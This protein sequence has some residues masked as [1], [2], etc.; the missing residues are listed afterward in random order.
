M[1]SPPPYGVPRAWTSVVVMPWSRRY[2][3]DQPP[4]LALPAISGDSQT[5]S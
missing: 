3:Y 2:M 4:L 1:N 5:S